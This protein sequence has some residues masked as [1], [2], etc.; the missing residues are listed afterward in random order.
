MLDQLLSTPEKEMENVSSD[1]EVADYF[2]YLDLNDVPSPTFTWGSDVESLSFGSLPYDNCVSTCG[3]FSTAKYYDAFGSE[4]ANVNNWA[5]VD[6]LGHGKHGDNNS[7]Y[8]GSSGWSSLDTSLCQSTSISPLNETSESVEEDVSS[9]NFWASTKY[10]SRNVQRENIEQRWIPDNRERRNRVCHRNKL[11]RARR[12]NLQRL[13]KKKNLRNSTCLRQPHYGTN[14]QPLVSTCGEKTSNKQTAVRKD[15]VTT[16]S[17]SGLKCNRAGNLNRSALFVNPHRLT[18]K[19]A[20]NMLMNKKAMALSFVTSQTGSRCMQKHLTFLTSD[21]LRSTFSCLKPDFV[22]VCQD[23]YGNYVAQKYV[24]LGSEDLKSAIVTTLKPSIPL[25]SVG[26]YGCR[27]VQKLLECASQEHKLM[28]A[29]QLAGSIMK[30]VHDQNGNHV[31]QKMIECLSPSEIGFVAEEIIGHTY[32]LAVHPYGSRVIQRLLEKLTRRMAEPLLKEI[33]QHIIALSKNQYGNYIIQ[34][35][36]N[37]CAIERREFVSKFIGRV[38]ELSR[39]KFSSNVIEQAIKR[40]TRPNVRELAAELLRDVSAPEGKYP[41][42]ARLVSDQYGNYVIQ[43]LLIK[44]SGD[45]RLR[46]LSC[47]SKCGKLNKNYG[48]NLLGKVEKM[49]RKKR[50]E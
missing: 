23:V 7:S 5:D 33:K 22:T 42:L 47:L 29:Q 32:R 44:S 39:E 28:V 12:R 15:T 10:E 2:K 50:I 40:S 1:S 13:R 14:N 45:F 46:L 6:S 37:Y 41:T 4:P 11:R 27:V 48:K 21:E 17:K 3:L 43:T 20:I 35:I 30:F 19:E 34:W 49:I 16:R 38:A 9:R 24:E 25:L 8:S 31:V 26:T 18:I 36:I